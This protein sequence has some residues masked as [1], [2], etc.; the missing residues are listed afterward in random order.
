MNNGIEQKKF[1]IHISQIIKYAWHA[2]VH[3]HVFL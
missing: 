1:T 2:N 3:V